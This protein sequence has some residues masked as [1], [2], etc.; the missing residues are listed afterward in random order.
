MINQFLTPLIFAVFA[1]GFA[2]I[3]LN[4]RQFRSAGLFTFS[5]FS[6]ALGFVLEAVLEE[7]EGFT[8]LPFLGDIFYIAAALFFTI[9]VFVRYDQ[10]VPVLM[11]A[12]VS[13]IL[14]A[15]I[16]WFRFV[17]HQVEMRVQ[18]VSYGCGALLLLGLWGIKGKSLHAIDR[19]LFWLIA[20]FGAQFFLTTY[21]ILK[22]DGEQ[23]TVANFSGS[24]FVAIT[25]F[26]VSALSLSIA[27]TLFVKYGMDIIRVLQAQSHT[28]DLTR[29]QNRRGFE[30]RAETLL[31]DAKSSGSPLSLIVCD[32]DHF[33]KI[34]DQYG[35]SAGDK[36]LQ[37][38]AAFIA[39][40]IRQSDLTGRVGGE[41]FC[42][43]LPGANISDA[44]KIAEK[45][46][47]R[48]E[49]KDFREQGIEGGLTVS[50]GI[51]E[52]EPGDTYESL[53]KRADAALYRAKRN[54]RN[55]AELEGGGLRA[56]PLASLHQIT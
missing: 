19:L 48:L 6:G 22:V 17:D 29:L 18:I 30:A 7:S 1:L 44:Y 10:R 54:G 52:L 50:C 53:F 14:L 33:K 43:L 47:T 39:G 3:W 38:F 34:N 41:E 42:L 11:L 21:L 26:I 56:L 16:T 25:N 31:Y 8:F 35:H 55:R 40:E 46:R 24:M 23:L 4:Y 49:A 51:A 28:D 9:A 20:F 36:A 2:I 15:G 5:Y 27:V 37:A 45:F 13:G 12:G 32:L